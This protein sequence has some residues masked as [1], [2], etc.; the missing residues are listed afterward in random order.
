MSESVFLP[1]YTIGDDAYSK[2]SE[3]CK[4]YGK[5]AVLIGGKTALEKSEA[6]IRQALEGSEVTVVDTL[7]YGGN[8]TYENIDKLIDHPSVQESDMLFAIGGGRCCDTVKTAAEKIGK[9]VF[10]FPTIAS[11]CSP[12]TAV[13]VIYKESGEMLGLF[14][15]KKPPKHTFINTKIIA[16]APDMYLW[17][18]IGDALSKEVESTFS[19]RGD[20]MDHTNALGVQIG[21]MCTERF[22]KYGEQA[23][24]DSEN[25]VSSYAIEQVLLDIIVTT[26]LVSVLVINDYNSALAH[27]FYYGTTLI[28]QGEKHL[29]GEIVSYGVLILLTMDKQYELRDRVYRFMRS[30][31]L[32]TSLTDLEIVE[33]SDI[34]I[35]LDKVMATNDIVH[36]PYVITREMVRESI[37][38]VEDYHQAHIG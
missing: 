31:K 12:T 3:I 17:A 9:P 36:V 26:G 13:C 18:G 21:Q 20:E 28:E 30:T 7:W 6:S 2:I 25:N 19:S 27:S 4:E 24:K 38:E 23:L 34:D 14:F 35:I 5:T 22:L 1:N 10:T 11:N 32:P 33:E 8:S 15:P 16:E 29:H 37:A